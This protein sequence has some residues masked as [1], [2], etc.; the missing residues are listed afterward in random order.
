MSVTVQ[1]LVDKIKCEVIYGDEAS[2]TK[3]IVTSD[4]LRPGLE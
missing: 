1:M 4:I 2:L 3:E